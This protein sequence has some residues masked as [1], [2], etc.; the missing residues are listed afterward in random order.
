MIRLCQWLR[1]QTN[2]D[3]VEHPGYCKDYLGFLR[4]SQEELDV[5]CDIASMYLCDLEGNQ[6]IINSMGEII[7]VNKQAQLQLDLPDTPYQPH[8][9]PKEL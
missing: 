2:G 7:L 4:I 1:D 8:R 9:L 6:F 3:M 5:L